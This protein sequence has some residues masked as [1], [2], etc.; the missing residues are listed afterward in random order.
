MMLH[1]HASVHIQQKIE[2]Q[3]KFY[4]EIKRNFKCPVGLSDHSPGFLHQ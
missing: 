3:F 4:E 1:F 2:N